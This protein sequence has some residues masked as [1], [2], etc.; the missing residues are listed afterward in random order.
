[1]LGRTVLLK[2][3]S[4][5]LVFVLMTQ[6]A[7][8]S[9]ACGWA[10]RAPAIAVQHAAA[11]EAPPCH[12]HAAAP[13]EGPFCLA[14]CLQ[15][16]QSLDRPSVAVAVLPNAPVLVVIPQPVFLADIGAGQDPAAGPPPRI[17]FQSLQ[18]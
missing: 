1:M 3:A 13:S 11:A 12:E 18:I 4:V 5:V 2:T 10:E 9:A 15:S 14:Y 17:L 8:V 7:F 16:V 6:I